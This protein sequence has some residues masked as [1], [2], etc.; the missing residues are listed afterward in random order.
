MSD[1]FSEK[2]FASDYLDNGK[3]WGVISD[4][5][6]IVI[7]YSVG[8]SSDQCKAIASYHNSKLDDPSGE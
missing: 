5:N 3:S 7:G 4:T 2:W 1:V 6:V 8:L